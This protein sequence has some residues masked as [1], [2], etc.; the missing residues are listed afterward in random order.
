MRMHPRTQNTTNAISAIFRLVRW[1]ELS[2]PNHINL[3]SGSARKSG[4]IHQEFVRTVLCRE[5]SKTRTLRFKIYGFLMNR[6][7][8]SPAVFHTL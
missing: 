1:F 4:D 5:S 7:G 2:A 8:F 6:S 3:T